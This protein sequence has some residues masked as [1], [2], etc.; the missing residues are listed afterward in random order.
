[1]SWRWNSSV[2]RKARHRPQPGPSP[3]A[4]RK[5]TAA[6]S[7]WM[8]SRNCLCPFRPSSYVIFKTGNSCAWAAPGS[9]KW[10]CGSLRPPAKSWPRRSAPVLSGKTSIICSAF[11]PSPCRLYGTAGRTFRRSSDLICPPL[12]LYRAG[13]G[14]LVEL[15]LARKCPGDGESGGA[16]VH[17]GGG[18]GNRS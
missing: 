2:P 18:L 9:E 13:V 11:F 8:R 7:S 12:L 5:P 15:R 1:M 4:W 17:H 6:V 14:S 16:P 10:M 3:V